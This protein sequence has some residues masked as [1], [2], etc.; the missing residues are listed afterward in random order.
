MPTNPQFNYESKGRINDADLFGKYKHTWVEE[1]FPQYDNGGREVNVAETKTYISASLSVKK[2]FILLAVCIL[3]TI[4]I[5]GRVFYLQALR[6][7]YYKNLAENNRVRIKPIAAERGLIYDREGNQLIDNIPSFSLSIVP[8]DLP[9]KQ[10]EKNAVIEQISKISGIDKTEIEKLIKKYSAYSYESLTVKDNLDYETALSLYIQNA[11][12]PGILIE[13]GTKRLYRTAYNSTSTPVLSLSHIL[14]YLG[15]IDDDELTDLKDKGY[16]PSDYLGKTGL[17]K[18]YET[19]L[20]GVYGRKK[21]EVNALGREQNVLAEEPPTPGRHLV[22]SIDL[23]AQEKMESLI[24]NALSKSKLTRAA[25]IAMNPENGEILALVSL[26]T[27]DNNDFSGGITS[28]KY[29]AYLANVDRP[30]FN[31]AISGTY[32]S[33]S[34]VKMLIA[35]AALEEGIITK[36]T[37]FLSTGGLQIDRWFFPDWKA[38]GHG[39]TNV[40]KA[41]AWSVNTFFYYI[42]GGYK[43]FTGLGVDRITSYLHKF[44]LS[45][46]TGVDLPSEATGFLPSMAWKLQNRNEPWYVGDTYNLSIG[47]GDLLVT[48][49]QVAA[50]TSAVANGGKVVVPHLVNSVINPVTEKQ[51]NYESHYANKEIISPAN[52]A[53]VKQGMRECVTYGSC[54]GLKGLSFTSGGKTGTAQWSATKGDHAWFTS[55]APYNQPKI[56]VTILVEEGIEGST[57]SQPIARSFLEWWGQK[58]LK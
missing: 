11:D 45:E 14:G 54:G 34:T 22:L 52:M 7:D 21:I 6:G 10:E 42:G 37:S 53:I 43:T 13:K 49:L 28:D 1:N 29:D 55:F 23:E 24:Q 39:Y 9:Q 56:V 19:Q 46:K 48:P 18:S 51:T 47:Q 8:Q 20:R 17:E 33:G 58:Y 38:G 32:P 15:K 3:G 44:G 5:F 50:W 40:T 27:F 16:L 41:L 31:R 2:I 25:G 57:M 35:A 12:T 30:L 4:I 36:T 26:P